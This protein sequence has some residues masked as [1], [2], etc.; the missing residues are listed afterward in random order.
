MFSYTNSPGRELDGTCIKEDGEVTIQARER[1]V[2]G[3]CMHTLRQPSGRSSFAFFAADA[4]L[5]ASNA[6][7][8]FSRRA[9]CLLSEGAAL[10]AAGAAVAVV[11]RQHGG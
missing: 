9:A 2:V 4:A 11:D 3:G 7:L 1:W 10:A 6:F 5:Y 8:F